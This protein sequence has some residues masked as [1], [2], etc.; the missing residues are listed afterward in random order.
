MHGAEHAARVVEAAI[1]DY[2]TLISGG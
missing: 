1:A 2:A